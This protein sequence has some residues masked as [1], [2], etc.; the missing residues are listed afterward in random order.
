MAIAAQE[1]DI[2]TRVAD[3]S[4]MIK[5]MIMEGRLF[6]VFKNQMELIRERSRYENDDELRDYLINESIILI[7]KVCSVV[8]RCESCHVKYRFRHCKNPIENNQR[9]HALELTCDGCGECYTFSEDRERVSYFNWNIL[10]KVDDLRRRSRGFTVKV[11]LGG[12]YKSA[13]LYIY[14]DRKPILWIDAYQITKADT[15]QQYWE[16]SKAFLKQ[17]KLNESTD[18]ECIE[19]EGG[20]IYTFTGSRYASILHVV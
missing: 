8:L 4:D 20:K 10:R 1:K 18:E 2:D 9:I 3:F 7:E 15:V 14:N 12:L 5:G 19:I 11:C 13:L 16:C 6:S 17:M